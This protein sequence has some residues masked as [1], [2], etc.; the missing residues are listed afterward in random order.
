MRKHSSPHA[1]A[2]HVESQSQVN[3]NL[4]TI[5]ALICSWP[6]S[7]ESGWACGTRD[8]KHLRVLK[9]LTLAVA[10]GELAIAHH[11]R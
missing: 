3:K 11:E 5:V 7:H 6:M 9:G 2:I 4:D 10:Y 8:H 1:R